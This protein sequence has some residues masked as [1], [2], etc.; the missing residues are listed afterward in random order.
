METKEI[1]RWTVKILIIIVLVYVITLLSDKYGE[2]RVMINGLGIA[3]IL[4]GTGKLLLKNK[5]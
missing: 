4:F 1:L 3:L 5:K 2:K